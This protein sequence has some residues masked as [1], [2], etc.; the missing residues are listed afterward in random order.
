MKKFF[1]SLFTVAAFCLSLFSAP[2]SAQY[3]YGNSFPFWNVQG[4]LSVTGS[5]NIGTVASNNLLFSATAPTIS[6]GF[7][8]SPSVSVA[9]S[10]ASF[11]VNVGTGGAATSGVIGLPTATNG[12]NCFVAPYAPAAA[13]LLNSTVVSASTTTTVTLSNLVNSSGSAAAWAA[14]QVLELSCFAY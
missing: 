3:I 4:V 7:G 14:S 6:S 5:E 1:L 13:Q 10:T 11:R 12:W 2:A 9:N 8:T